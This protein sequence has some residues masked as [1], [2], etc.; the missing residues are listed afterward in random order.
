MPSGVFHDSIDRDAV[1][2][3]VKKYRL[4][5]DSVTMNTL[6]KATVSYY[7]VMRNSVNLK[8][9]VVFLVGDDTQQILVRA[10]VR[11]VSVMPPSRTP[12]A[13]PLVSIPTAPG[14]L[15]QVDMWGPYP[16]GRSEES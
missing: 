13:S 16:S 10:T 4:K 15:G 8:D 14:Q 12:T 11:I 5:S 3:L 6:L 1:V 7:R 2:I 9:D